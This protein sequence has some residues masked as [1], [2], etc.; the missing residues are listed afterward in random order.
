MAYTGPTQL[1]I[2]H[3]S[4]V[5][6]CRCRGICDVFLLSTG[7]D[8]SCRAQLT[9]TTRFQLKNDQ[10]DRHSCDAFPCVSQEA[11][12]TKLGSWH[13]RSE[14]ETS[15]PPLQAF[16][17]NALRSLKNEF[18]LPGREVE[19]PPEPFKVVILL[20]VWDSSNS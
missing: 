16:I 15:L 6:F 5:L 18:L 13:S 1:S 12:P 3:V 19:E 2:R 20:K 11:S 4:S 10:H 8:P 17:S 7:A 14:S 9:K